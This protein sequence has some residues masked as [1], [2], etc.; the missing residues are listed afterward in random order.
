MT[1]PRPLRDPRP[2]MVFS[3]AGFAAFL[4][5][6]GVSVFVIG[7]WIA[8]RIWPESMGETQ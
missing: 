6:V 5:A 1:G 8:N 3:V 4:T 7:V 2:V